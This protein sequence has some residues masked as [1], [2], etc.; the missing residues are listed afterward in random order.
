MGKA[1]VRGCASVYRVSLDGGTPER[2]ASYGDAQRW[3]WDGLRAHPER[4]ATV[5]ILALN[6]HEWLTRERWTV[7]PSGRFRH[8]YVGGP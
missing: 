2:F 4:T 6:P 8:E 1:N 7:G 5:E 3:A